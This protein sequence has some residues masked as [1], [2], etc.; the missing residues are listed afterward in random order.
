MTQDMQATFARRIA[1]LGADVD[2]QTAPR[3]AQYH[4]LLCDWNTRMNLTGDTSLDTSLSRLYMDSLA[5]LVQGFLFPRGSSL[6]DV[7]SGAGFPGLPLAIARP[8]LNVLLVD[9]LGKRVAFLRAVIDSLGL[10]NVEAVHA[11]AEDAAWHADYRE[12]FDVAVA[13]AVATAPVLLEYL[14]PFVRVGG[15]ALCYKGPAAEEELDAGTRAAYLL[16][17]GTLQVI[18]V[19]V[20]EE[21]DWQHCVLVCKKQRKTSAYFPRKSGL[22]AKEPLGEERL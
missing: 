1:L 14:L 20:P 5:P 8:D 4:A 19:T 12:C 7:G 17:G 2:A 16:G 10:T 18:P 9:S 6:V 13:R 22:P 15:H 11:R 3:L 21:P